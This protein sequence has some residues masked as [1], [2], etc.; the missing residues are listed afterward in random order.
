MDTLT[1]IVIGA[2]IGELVAGKQLGRKAM[3]LGAMVQVLPD[4]DVISALWLP[5][6]RE[7]L[8]HRGFTHSILF[9]L[10][11]SFLLAFSSAFWIKKPI[12]LGQWW[13]FFSIQLF[14]HLFI[15]AFNV[16]GTGWFEPFS[17]YRVS[18]NTIFVIDPLF[19]IAP[20]IVCVPL[21]FPI[22]NYYK[23][24]RLAAMGLSISAGY[25]FFCIENKLMIDSEIKTALRQQQIRYSSFFTTPTPLNNL[26]WYAVVKDTNRYN[27]AYV[28]IFDNPANIHFRHYISNNEL[29]N[30]EN[31]DLSYLVRFSKGYYTIEQWHDTLVF[32]DM[33]FGRIVGWQDTASHFTFHFFLYQNADNSFVV[34]RGRLADWNKSSL[35]SLA[36]RIMDN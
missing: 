30:H 6:V 28:S 14:V 22:K 7:L 8:A 11:T 3:L 29:I 9:A 36:K 27:V 25:L 31:K 12:P 10:L 20:A 19:S 32:N 21:L 26:L 5:N 33:R 2:C 1:H 16:Y 15:D 23:R 17:H 35:K 4:I 13:A 24:K 18:F 34:Q